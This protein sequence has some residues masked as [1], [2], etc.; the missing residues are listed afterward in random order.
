[1]QHSPIKPRLQGLIGAMS[2][3]SWSLGP[4]P[5]SLPPKYI[6]LFLQLTF[7]VA[8]TLSSAS[9]SGNR[10]Q[11]ETKVR[12]RTNSRMPCD[13]FTSQGALLDIVRKLNFFVGLLGPEWRQRPVGFLF[14]SLEECPNRCPKME[15]AVW[16]ETKSLLTGDALIF[17]W[18][19]FEDQEGGSS[20]SKI[21]W[22]S[23]HE[24]H[25]LQI[26]GCCGSPG[27]KVLR[28]ISLVVQWLRLRAP[29]AGGLGL[30]LVQ[31]LDTT[32]HNWEFTCRN[33]RPHLSR[34]K[35]PTCHH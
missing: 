30:I 22:F 3:S 26:L 9:D 12:S 6:R 13:W 23:A 25:W 4:S 7:N 33:W 8:P 19:I 27:E 20:T 35:D 24:V 15:R 14:K 28:G 18:K 16:K 32:Y 21:P 5:P 10:E 34:L 17:D 31:E 1:M 11:V 29:N 2:T